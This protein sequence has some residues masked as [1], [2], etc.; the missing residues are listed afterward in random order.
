MVD[1]NI[2][3]LFLAS[4]LESERRMDSMKERDAEMNRE[5]ACLEGDTGRKREKSREGDREREIEGRRER[6]RRGDRVREGKR[7]EIAFK[8]RDR[9]PTMFV[10]YFFMLVFLYLY[11]I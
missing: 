10:K 4:C 1:C 7:E 3:N 11:F 6:E 8:G 5:R 2:F 9:I